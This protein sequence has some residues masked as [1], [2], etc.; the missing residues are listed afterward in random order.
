MAWFTAGETH[1]TGRSKFLQRKQ[2]YLKETDTEA[3]R[4]V[5]IKLPIY[6]YILYLEISA[7][8][9]MS[10]CLNQSIKRTLFLPNFQFSTRLR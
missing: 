4:E 2:V 9:L 3:F 7:F 1:L 10:L 8:L 6:H 5:N